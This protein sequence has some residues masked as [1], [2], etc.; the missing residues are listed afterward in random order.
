MA[1]ALLIRPTRDKEHSCSYTIVLILDC[2][3]IYSLC[4]NITGFKFIFDWCTNLLYIDGETQEILFLNLFLSVKNF[5]YITTS[6][7][8][9]K[10]IIPIIIEIPSSL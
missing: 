2:L 5:L 9:Y 3:S 1:V 6:F 4:E 8:I 10:Y 7:H